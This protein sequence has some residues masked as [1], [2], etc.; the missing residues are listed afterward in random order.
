[1]KKIARPIL[2]GVTSILKLNNCLTLNFYRVPHASGVFRLN[3]LP[4]VDSRMQKM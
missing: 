4:V 1:M 2:T 3:L